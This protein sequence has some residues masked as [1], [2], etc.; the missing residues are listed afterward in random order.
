MNRFL[1]LMRMSLILAAP[2]AALAAGQEAP[3]TAKNQVPAFP[4]AEGAGATATGGRGGK[5]VHVTNLNPSGPGSLADAVSQPNRIVVFDVSGAIDMMYEKSASEPKPDEAKTGKAEKEA[6]AKLKKIKEGKSDEKT[7]EKKLMRR[8]DEM[9]NAKEHPDLEPKLK[10]KTLNVTQPNITIAGQTA[11]GEGI[12]IIHGALSVSASNVIVRHLRVRRGHIT[13][14]DMGDGMTVKGEDRDKPL[15]DVILDH[16]STCWTT[17]ENI[18]MT[19]SVANGTVQYAIAAEGLDHFNPPQTPPKHSEGSLFGS[20]LPGGV[21]NFHHVIYAHNRLRNPRFTGGGDP[22]PII[23]LRNSV[24]YN[25][26]EAMAMTGS[27][28]AAGNLINNYFKYGVDSFEGLR[29]ALFNFHNKKDDAFCLYAAGNVA[30]G[31]PDVT[32]DNW[33]GMRYQSSWDIREKGDQKVEKMDKPFPMAP[34]TMQT[35]QEAYETCLAESGATLPSRDW[36]DHRIVTDVRFGCGR[37]IDRETDLPE[38]FRWC[39]YWPLPAPADKD[40]DGMPDYWE[41]QYGLDPNKD[42]S[43]GDLDGDGYTNIEEYLNNMDPKGGDTPGGG[44]QVVYVHATV[45]RAD[46]YDRIPGEIQAARV[47]KTDKELVV[48]Y[49]CGGTAKSKDDYEPLSGEVRIPAGKTSAAILV[50]PSK[51]NV[52]TESDMRIVQAKKDASVVVT[53]ERGDGYNVGC[54]RA[55]MIVIRPY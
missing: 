25:G 20:D 22:R 52:K 31:Y 17:D 29:G 16:V 14:G 53:L 54:P 3:A 19:A 8:E 35:A 43:A 21:V 51:E 32:Q 26:K 15:R 2:L 1:M 55:A 48:K 40:Q 37:I 49:S 38:K 27:G 39:A 46:G 9:K 10:G 6:D 13:P 34:M 11:P 36:I 42:D 30:E 41:A 24:I 4:G 33:K 23:D 7:K 12:A 28:G 5:V 45:S 18:T 50:T 44:T 47:G